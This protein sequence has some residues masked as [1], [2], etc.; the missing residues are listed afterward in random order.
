MVAI[1]QRRLARMIAMV[2]LFEADA[3]GHDARAI[4]TR[5]AYEGFDVAMITAEA[6]DTDPI[7]NATLKGKAPCSEIF[8]GLESGMLNVEGKTFA[9][10]LVNGVHGQMEALDRIIATSATN[11]PVDQIALVDKAI[12]RLAIYELVFDSDVPVKAVIN[13]AIELG[14]CFGSDSSGRFIN[15]VLGSVVNQLDTYRGARNGHT[16]MAEGEA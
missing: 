6:E 16:G 8:L 11:W 12:L 2:A 7:I 1:V 5:Y 14:K 9:V 3:V 10:R 4:I 15:G 13:E